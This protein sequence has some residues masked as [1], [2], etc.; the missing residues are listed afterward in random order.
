MILFDVG[1]TTI[2]QHFL[3]PFGLILPHHFVKNFKDKHDDIT[4]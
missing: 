4:I 1:V 2:S 3:L